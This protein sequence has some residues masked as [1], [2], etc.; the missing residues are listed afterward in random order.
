M[1]FKTRSS[2]I[3]RIRRNALV[4]TIVATGAFLHVGASEKKPEA[5][6]TPEAEPTEIPRPDVLNIKK[7]T[8]AD[9]LLK[10]DWLRLTLLKMSDV[11]GLK[12]IPEVADLSLRKRI[13]ENFGLPAVMTMKD[14]ARSPPQW[15]TPESRGLAALELGPTRH[16][17]RPQL[18]IEVPML[19]LREIPFLNGETDFVRSM[20]EIVRLWTLG[21]TPE[22]TKLRAELQKLKKKVPRG[23]LER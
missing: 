19:R 20:N 4:A 17:A 23:T 11:P 13:A 7:F 1:G 14:A 18:K 10:R 6:P 2:Q 12:Q 9:E 16:F 15:W 5:T 3:T 22:A 8:P 21:R